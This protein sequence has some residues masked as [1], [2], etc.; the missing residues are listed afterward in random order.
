MKL[1]YIIF[2][3]DAEANNANKFT[4]CLNKLNII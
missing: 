1:I 2:P 3:W 4:A